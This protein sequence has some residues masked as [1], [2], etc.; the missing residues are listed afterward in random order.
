MYNHGI[1]E[2]YHTSL[3]YI[4]H[5]LSYSYHLHSP[6]VQWRRDLGRYTLT[7]IHGWGWMPFIA[8]YCVTGI[9]FLVALRPLYPCACNFPVQCICWTRSPKSSPATLNVA[10]HI[11]K[12]P[13]HLWLTRKTSTGVWLHK[14]NDLLPIKNAFAP[15]TPTSPMLLGSSEN[16]AWFHVARWTHEQVAQNKG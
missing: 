8:F 1:W 5:I 9:C 16:V 4:Y 6:S 13:M 14:P 15:S 10:A 7:Q 2:N 3:T 12:S 11:S